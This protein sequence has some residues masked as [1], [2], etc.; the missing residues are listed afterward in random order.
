M[1]SSISEDNGQLNQV[2]PADN[3]NFENAQRQEGLA[4]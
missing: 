4:V 1:V 2:N 3:V